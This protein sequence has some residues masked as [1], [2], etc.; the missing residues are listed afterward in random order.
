MIC[1]IRRV[2]ERIVGQ[3]RRLPH[4]Q[5]ATEAVALQFPTLGCSVLL[6]AQSIHL[7]VDR[8][9]CFILGIG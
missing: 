4:T 7:S 8:L 1:R 2:N 5:T 6:Q 3:A 9:I